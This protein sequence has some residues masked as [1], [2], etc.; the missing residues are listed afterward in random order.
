MLVD[1]LGAGAAAGSPWREADRAGTRRG[2][3]A[4]RFRQTI[5][6]GLSERAL[7]ATIRLAGGVRDTVRRRFRPQGVPSHD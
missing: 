6:G 3:G 4:G 2:D 5:V 7:Q 1:P